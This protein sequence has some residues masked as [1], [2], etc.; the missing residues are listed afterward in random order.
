MAIGKLPEA[1]VEG[2]E[3]TIFAEINITPLTDVFLVMLI[4][5]M[6]ASSVTAEAD[7]EKV[8]KI[9]EKA[10]AEK[11]S[12]IKINM[13]KGETQEIDPTKPSLVVTILKSGEVIIEDKKLTQEKLGKVFERAFGQ[14]NEIQ[15][16]LKADTGV[17][18]GRVVEV[19]EA[20]RK[21]GITRLA[22]GTA[23]G[24]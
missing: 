5:F 9:E 6:V 3:D 10:E 24:G 22:I 20:A 11:R 4:I 13:P 14:N 15:V 8:E 2:S 1:D 7:R 16:V 19:M 18:H 17:P 23:G 12:G 21:Q